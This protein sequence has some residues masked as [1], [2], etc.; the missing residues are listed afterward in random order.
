MIFLQAI[1][2]LR[3]ELELSKALKLFSILFRNY[4]DTFK[5]VIRNEEISLR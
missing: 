2:K 5:A 1:Q 4:R 3:N